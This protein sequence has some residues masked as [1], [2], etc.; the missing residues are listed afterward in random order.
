MP[1]LPE[2]E[3]M[4]RALDGWTAGRSLV[5]VTPVDPGLVDAPQRLQGQRIEGARRRGKYLLLQLDTHAL[6]LHLR[7]T[8]KVVAWRADE[9]IRQGCRLLLHL[10]GPRPPAAVALVD[11][12]RLAQAW[13][14]STEQ[15]SRWLEDR[16]LGPDAWPD[17]RSGA[18]WAQRMA[19]LRGPIKAALLR[20][21]RVA[22]LGNIAATEV[23]WRA[24][25]HPARPVP[26]LV[27]AD[28]EALAVAVPDYVDQVLA[29]E[30]AEMQRQ[31][32]LS[33]VNQGGPNP[34]DLYGRA[35]QPCPRCGTPVQRN[36]LAGRGTAWCPRCQPAGA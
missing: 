33:Y 1:E 2:V 7:M 11:P 17:R 9:G 14:V 18:W 31:G 26:S 25:I 4:C 28:W 23:L 29:H 34:F 30:G 19:G 36:T 12:R 13:I 6:A 32:E 10:S 3:L 21:D 24:G 20:Q 35:G 8:G 16:G 5:G 22:G 27:P 15:L